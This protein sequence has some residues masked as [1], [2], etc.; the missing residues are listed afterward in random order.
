M[1][2]AEYSAEMEM[3]MSSEALTLYKL[4][5]LYMLGKINFPLTNAQISGFI[6][7]REYTNYF[8]L[9]QVIS[10]L[11]D[12]D[13]ISVKTLG[14]TSYYHITSQGRETLGFFANKISPSI[15]EDIDTFLLENKYELRNEA[16]TVA[17]YYKSTNGNY[18]VHCQT[19]EGA[20]TLI[21]LNL[22][23]PTEEAAEHMCN[24]WKNASEDIYAYVIQRL[25]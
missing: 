24:N 6:L 17:D 5:I 21:E 1:I 19:K 8:T 3:Y 20:Q 13:L 7:D 22:S 14:N 11:L 4:I 15:Q 12:A 10:E 25:K 16:G 23:I 18:I 2:C 9:Q